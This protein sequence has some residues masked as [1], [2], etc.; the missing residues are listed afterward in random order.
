MS[1]RKKQKSRDRRTGEPHI[2]E[3][4]GIETTFM[5]PDGTTRLHQMLLVTRWSDGTIQTD[6]ITHNP[7]L[8]EILA[9]SMPAGSVTVP[10][11]KVA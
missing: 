7:R 10:W 1:A 3:A 6:D 11:G 5:M 2:V 9:A 8:D 4:R